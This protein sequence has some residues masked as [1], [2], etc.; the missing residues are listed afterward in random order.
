VRGR[1]VNLPSDAVGERRVSDAILVL[2]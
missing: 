1:A 2:P